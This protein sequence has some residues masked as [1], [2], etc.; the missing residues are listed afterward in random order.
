LSTIV[1]KIL[2]VE[3]EPLIALTLEDMLMELGYEV[4]GT[5]SR[6]KDALQF[7]ET[8]SFDG[9]LLDVNIGRE[10]IDPVAERLMD[11]GCPFVFTTGDGPAS[12]PA[13]FN[14]ACFVAKPFRMEELAAALART[15]PL[16]A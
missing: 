9:A 11:R 13:A 15:V 8:E 6:V 10:R 2:I 3:D 4:A 14:K 12:V 5:M 16:K 1:P 7:I